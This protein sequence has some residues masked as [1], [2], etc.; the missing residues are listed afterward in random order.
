MALWVML[1]AS[2]GVLMFH[3]V[4]GG[5]VTADL[6]AGP[7]RDQAEAVSAQLHCLA[8]QVELVVPRR[9][10]VHVSPSL[11]VELQQR[12]SELIVYSGAEVVPD[13]AAADLLLGAHPVEQT[14]CPNLYTQPA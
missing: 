8:D 9:S 2:A 14:D 4:H 13:P 3:A 6:L 12:V 1:V 11:G 5:R 7:W 10:R